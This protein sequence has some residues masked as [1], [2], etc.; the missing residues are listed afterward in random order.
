M[1]AALGGSPPLILL[2]WGNDTSH[3]QE[4]DSEACCADPLTDRRETHDDL[5]PHPG[6]RQP[7]GGGSHQI[8]EI[9]GQPGSQ[10]SSGAGLSGGA[11]SASWLPM[12]MCTL[13]SPPYLHPHPLS[14]PLWSPDLFQI[15]LTGP[16]S[17]SSS[18]PYPSDPRGKR[19]CPFFWGQRKARGGR[20]LRLTNSASWAGSPPGH[21]L[22]RL[23]D[24]KTLQAQLVKSGEEAAAGGPVS[25]LGTTS[26]DRVPVTEQGKA[27]FCPHVVN[28]GTASLENTAG[29]VVSPGEGQLSSRAW[30]LQQP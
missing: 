23:T 2:P 11:P 28:G 30:F 18:P 24:Q 19:S 8:P 1:Q 14:C 16:I 20:T 29:P 25:F 10:G 7:P 9:C 26:Q 17:F 4:G 22:L 21:R 27:C 15:S 3:C 13:P 6:Q 5:Y 12:V